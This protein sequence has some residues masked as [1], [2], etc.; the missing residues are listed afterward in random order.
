MSPANKTG[1]MSALCKF[2][3]IYQINKIVEMPPATKNVWIA[4]NK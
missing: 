3:E 2:K 4:K 1:M